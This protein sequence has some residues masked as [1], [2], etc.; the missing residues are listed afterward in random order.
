MA[1]APNIQIETKHTNEQLCVSVFVLN[2]YNYVLSLVVVAKKE[3]NDDKKCRQIT[4]H[5]D[6]RDAAVQFGVHRPMEHIPSFTRSHWMPPL[7][8]C[9]RPGG[10]HGP[11]IRCK[12]QNTNKKPF[13][14]LANL[15]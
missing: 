7:G 10:R 2:G 6:D 14:T 12:T 9:L 15:Q 11:R 3:I 5:F 4:G 8:E 13:F 1:D